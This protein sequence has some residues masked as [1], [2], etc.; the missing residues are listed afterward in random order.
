VGDRMFNKTW[1][2]QHIGCAEAYEVRFDEPMSKHT[3]LSI[4]GPA[5]IFVLPEG[6]GGFERLVVEVSRHGVPLTVVGGGSNLLVLDG[7]LEGVVVSL[8]RLA[9]ISDGA[10]DRDAGR[11]VAGSGVSLSRLVRYCAEKGYS[12]LEWASGIP[13]LLGGA[14]RMN[15]GA[16]GFEIKDAIENLVLMDRTGR[17]YRMSRPEIPFGYRDWGLGEDR[18]VIAAELAFGLAEPVDVL[19][20]T[21]LY[22]EEKRQSQPVSERSAGS[23]FRNPQGNSAWE[24]I[25]RSGLRGASEGGIR[26]SERHTNFFVSDGTGS[27]EQFLTLLE[28]V[29]RTVLDVTGIRLEPEIHIMGRARSMHV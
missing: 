17:I 15:A 20:R 7:G 2:D 27:A 16:F 6:A 3:T 24:L 14:V 9:R 8:R 28:R 13:G 11:L 22:L 21:T 25:D 23:V 12:G 29:T 19:N 1:W 18:F 26:I 10:S 4:G 5:D